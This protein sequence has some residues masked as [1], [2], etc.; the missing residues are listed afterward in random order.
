MAVGKRDIKIIKGDDYSHVVTLS[1]RSNGVV[2][3]VDITGRTYTADLRESSA[4]APVAD[5][6]C[7]VTDG[8]NGE[9]TISM[10][11]AVTADIVAGCYQWTLVQ[12]ASGVVNTILGGEANV[13][14]R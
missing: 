4:S 13:V 12:D 2:T 10:G 8:P 7:V 5:F 11:H 6:Q 9:V 1:V 3:P 14:T